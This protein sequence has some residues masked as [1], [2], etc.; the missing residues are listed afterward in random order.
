[1]IISIKMK[2]YR[3]NVHETSPHLLLHYV[4][5]PPDVLNVKNFWYELNKITY[6]EVFYV[7]KN[8]K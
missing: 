8:A 5:R 3:V 4:K 1:M 7:V 2:R 6:D